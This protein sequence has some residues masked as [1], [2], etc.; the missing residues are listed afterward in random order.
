MK[1]HRGRR[2]GIRDAEFHVTRRQVAFD[3]GPSRTVWGHEELSTASIAV[4]SLTST[5]S[6]PAH[7]A[8]AVKPRRTSSGPMRHPTGGV[9]RETWNRPTARHLCRTIN[10]TQRVDN[11]RQFE[12]SAVLG[13]HGPAPTGPGACG[14]RVPRRTLAPSRQAT[15]SNNRGVSRGTSASWEGSHPF[16][17]ARRQGTGRCRSAAD[18][19][20]SSIHRCV[21][22]GG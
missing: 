5:R 1:A 14:C 9:S 10:Q 12:Q 3:S 11:R 2:S 4:A 20:C 7:I 18:G 22:N 8:F 16:T 21:H 17:T 19:R 15:I 6:A 13:T